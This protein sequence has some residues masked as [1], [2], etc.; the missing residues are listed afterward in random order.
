VSKLSEGFKTALL[1]LERDRSW[2]PI[3]QVLMQPSEEMVIMM[4]FSLLFSIT[5]KTSIPLILKKKRRWVLISWKG[6]KRSPKKPICV[7]LTFQDN[8]SIR[9][10]Y[11]GNLAGFFT[12]QNVL[13]EVKV[14]VG[15]SSSIFVFQ[16]RVRSLLGIRKRG[17]GGGE[18]EEW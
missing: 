2:A 12:C 6:K 17:G 9:Y 13:V 18:G 1:S 7:P 4:L 3:S 10:S 14:D 11:Y 5:D 15:N 8:F 16:D